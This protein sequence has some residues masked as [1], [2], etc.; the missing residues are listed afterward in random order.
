MTKNNKRTSGLKSPVPDTL[1][2][3]ILLALAITMNVAGVEAA[4]APNWKNSFEVE[5]CFSYARS[6]NFRDLYGN[7]VTVG[8]R[9]ER[10]VTNSLGLGLRVSRIQVS[11]PE[12]IAPSTL[13]LKDF[14]VVPMISYS[15]A[16][17][18]NLRFFVGGGVG[19]SF[20]EVTV[21]STYLAGSGDIETAY[22]AQ[23]SETSAYGLLMVG[24]D[25]RL[26]DFFF[27]GARLSNDLH[28]LSDAE[29]GDLGDTGS[30]RI[31]G[32]LGFG[33]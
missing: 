4:P 27:L 1:V 10:L 24:A 2:L 11:E 13:T 17:T 14:A 9:Y 18:D 25:L 28:I 19:L 30:F 12:L 33:F 32:S 3:L 23:Q 29:V 21:E 6:E 8:A 7:G 31:G 15:L 5:G 20:R 26:G 22:E 16:P